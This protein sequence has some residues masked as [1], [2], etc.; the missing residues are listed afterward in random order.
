[1]VMKRNT[2]YSS[3]FYFIIVLW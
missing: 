1:M 3:A 2:N